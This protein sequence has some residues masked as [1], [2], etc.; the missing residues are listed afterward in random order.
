MLFT[1]SAIVCGGVRRSIVIVTYLRDN[2]SMQTIEIPIEA[3][4]QALGEPTRLRIIRLMA[5]TDEEICLCELVDSL[6][7]P[8]Y[9]LSRHLK[10]LRQSGLLE[11]EKEGRWVY[12]RLS[13]GADVL[14]N[15][16]EYV[17]TLPDQ[18]G[19]FDADLLRFQERLS[20]REDGRCRVGVLS[21]AL[22]SKAS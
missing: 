13:S 3:I 12:H 8:Q 4:F 20:H 11:S 6:L 1:R 15:L 17:T 9:K 10:V 19:S 18:D 16:F 2:A 21:A 5:V 14:R 22:E 7:E